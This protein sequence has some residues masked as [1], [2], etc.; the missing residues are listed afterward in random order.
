MSEVREA[1]ERFENRKNAAGAF[2]N[3]KT[4]DDDGARMI[5]SGLDLDLEELRIFKEASARAGIAHMNAMLESGTDIN[6]AI[7]QV[8]GSIWVDGV[9]TGMMIQEGR[10]K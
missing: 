3:D 4:T 7:S 10:E 6:A 9:A 1:V 2:E 5:L 8:I